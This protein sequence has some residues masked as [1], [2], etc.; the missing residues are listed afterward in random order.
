V[1]TVEDA[2]GRR[3][4]LVK[5]SRESSLVRDVETGR[6]R[7]VPNDD[8]EALR[9]VEG[10]DPLSAAASAVPPP[11]R[12]LVSAVHDDRGLGLLVALAREPRSARWLLDAT[13]I[14][15]SDLH[16][17]V[18][19]LRAAGLVREATVAGERG[20]AATDEARRAVAPLLSGD[21]EGDDEGRAVVGGDEAE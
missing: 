2:D 4:V 20:Y 14:C 18:S 3:Y 1:H 13:E 15:E 16:G 12:R 19:E 11:L 21:V 7:Y 17:L 9:P 8:L 10:V 6:A 5:R